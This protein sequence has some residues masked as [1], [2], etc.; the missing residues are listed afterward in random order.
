MQVQELGFATQGVAMLTV[1]ARYAGYEEPEARRMYQELRRRIAAIPGVQSVFLTSGSPVGSSVGRQIEI[2][3]PASAAMTTFSAESAWASPG[4]F[5]TL[6]IPVLFG[7]AFQDQDLP[8]KPH[9]AVVNET[10]ARRIFGSPNA[11]GRRFRY[12]GIEGS[13]EE[14]TP[15]EIVG[16]VRDS[17]S[18]Q[19]P[20]R[21]E[22]LFY[23]PAAQAGVETSTVGARTALDAA[24]LLQAMQKEVRSLDPSL[25]VL[26]A[27]TMEQLLENRL[28]IW[29]RASA[30]LGGL[31]ALALA[32]AS[33]GLYAV[34]RFAASKRSRELGIRVALGAR[35][36]QV[37]WL[38]MRDVAILIGVAIA[39]GSAVS[40]AGLALVESMIAGPSG[41]PVTIPGADRI[42]LLWVI[43]L[44]AGTA[45][46]AAYFPARRAAKR[47]PWQSL[48][49]G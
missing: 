39:A 3:G 21:P 14:R 9:V 16:V 45:G 38:V 44:L 28:R 22:P 42:T 41:A 47:D 19:Y 40:V 35:A 12:S 48:R 27:R 25:H 5:E 30:V 20:A 8:G 43:V 32:L 15:V 46:A 33:V 31:G 7:R 18:L 13:R 34:V 23:L 4:V 10:M 29:R 26:Q 2:D 49:Q 36:P 11:V 6:Q 24:A 37:V 17:S 1:S